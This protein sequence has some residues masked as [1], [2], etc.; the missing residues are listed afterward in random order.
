MLWQML[1]QIVAQTIKKGFPALVMLAL[2]GLWLACGP[3][4][5]SGAAKGE[6]LLREGKIAES[7]K[8]LQVAASE[9]GADWQ[10]FNLLGM[11]QQRAGNR[12]AALRAYKKVLS[13]AE[14][15]ASLIHS[16]LPVHY[17][18]GRLYLDAGKAS[19]AARE[20]ATYTLGNG[21]SF[22]GFYWRGTAE[23][24]AA[25]Q[26]NQ[27]AMLDRAESS[28][29]KAIE[30]KSDSAEAF[31]RL[32]LV[33]LQRGE[34]ERALANFQRARQVDAKF[35][36]AILNLAVYHQKHNTTDTVQSRQKALQLYIEY[37]SLEGVDL[38]RKEAAQLALNRLN[39]Q[40]NPAVL[41]ELGTDTQQPSTPPLSG[42]VESNEVVTVRFP[43]AGTGP[44]RGT[45]VGVYP[46]NVAN[47]LTIRP[48]VVNPPPKPPPVVP[49][50]PPVAPKPV[51]VKQ[52]VVP[53]PPPPVKPVTPP[54]PI[55]AA[56]PNPVPKPP[57]PVVVKTPE[58]PEFTETLPKLPSIS[59]YNYR[60]LKL[61]KAG[62]RPEANK[63]FKKGL[64]AHKLNRMEEAM[65]H[66]RASLKADPA[67]QQA[68]ANLALAAHQSGNMPEALQAYEMALNINPLSLDSRYHFALAL[69]KAGYHID[70]ANELNR[71]LKDYPDL[72]RGHLLMANLFDKH[73]EQ[74]RRARTHYSKVIQLNPSHSE[75]PGIRQWLSEHP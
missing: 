58:P 73:L 27:A 12:S 41:A 37:L 25:R 69:N 14:A 47:R 46:T 15:D 42:L 40:I 10:V 3:A 34:S 5:D 43:R 61:P 13:M 52:P 23:L 51:A 49:P 17:N 70:A 2:T 72:L 33:Y 71:L 48:P 55:A 67:Y 44:V 22:A 54:K 18:L 38:A 75:A 64:Y 21:K 30:L 62:N 20:L 31:N 6:Q 59:R 8:V 9:K 63:H 32:A 4:G 24:M 57:A 11:A 35:A 45:I 68:Y 7:V 28:L 60:D 36:P 56:K 39:Q 50:S 16:V 65:S 26:L 74:P 53:E 66:Y 1:P 19:E 29:R